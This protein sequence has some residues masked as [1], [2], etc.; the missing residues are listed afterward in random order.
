VANISVLLT[1]RVVR[2]CRALDLYGYIV[3]MP[4]RFNTQSQGL[5][6][7]ARRPTLYGDPTVLLDIVELWHAGNDPD[8]LGLESES[9]H[10]Q[11]ASWNAQVGGDRP[12]DSERLDI[13]RSKADQVI[14]HRHP[15][16]RP[17]AVR[18]PSAFPSLER[19]LQS[20][21]E[22]VFERHSILQDEKD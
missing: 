5:A 4:I 7:R 13:D 11:G 12:E 9:C 14:V 3:E 18:R 1:N 17:N 22:L 16:G 15:Y 21:E 20:V 8:G 19:W 10:L 6:L 2:W